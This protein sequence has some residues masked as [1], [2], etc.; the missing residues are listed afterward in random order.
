VFAEELTSVARYRRMTA[1]LEL[2]LFRRLRTRP[3]KAVAEEF[4]L[5]EGRVQRILERLG[6]R[7]VQSRP[8]PKPKF[9]GV[10]E[11][12]A[13]RGQ[14]YNT[15]FVNLEERRILDVVETRENRGGGSL[16]PMAVLVAEKPTSRRSSDY[17][18]SGYPQS[19]L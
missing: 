1:R 12:A 4:R 3:T 19:H 15:V 10:D 9:L 6:D 8:Q 16:M 18:S 7:E 11:F 14:V 2:A 13:K 17:G 5:G